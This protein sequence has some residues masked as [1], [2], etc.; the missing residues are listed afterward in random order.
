ME[1]ADLASSWYFNICE[2]NLLCRAKEEG[3]KSQ[4]GDFAFLVSFDA[5]FQ[6]SFGPK[7]KLWFS[8]KILSYFKFL[9]LKK[10]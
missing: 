3:R 5:E 8:S 7:R 4:M 10:T 1:E 6:A 2:G 9:F